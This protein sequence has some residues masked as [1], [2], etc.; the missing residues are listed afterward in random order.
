MSDLQS[1]PFRPNPE[2]CCEACVFGSGVHEPWCPQ[3]T[4]RLY[5]ELLALGS[6]VPSSA[7]ETVAGGQQSASSELARKY[8]AAIEATRQMLA[9]DDD[10]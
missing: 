5:L 10:D 2:Q 4:C 6:S 7:A 9:E 1:R 3:E 8:G